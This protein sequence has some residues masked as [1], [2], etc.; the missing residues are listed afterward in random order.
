MKVSED[1]NHCVRTLWKWKELEPFRISGRPQLRRPLSRFPHNK[2]GGDTEL[3]KD[4]IVN[5]V[6]LVDDLIKR[7]GMM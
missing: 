5:N 4:S 6:I 3:T 2:R 7:E 1:M